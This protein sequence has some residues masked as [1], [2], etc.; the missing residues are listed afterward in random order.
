M[1]G[2]NGL[3]LKHL[4]SVQLSECENC[5][6]EN[7]TIW[8]LTH[9]TSHDCRALFPTIPLLIA[10][11]FVQHAPDC[12]RPYVSQLYGIG[13]LRRRLQGEIY[14]YT[15]THT[16]IIIMLNLNICKFNG[17]VKVIIFN[18]KDTNYIN[19]FCCFCLLFCLLW[20]SVKPLI[21]LITTYF[22]QN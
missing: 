5:L 11:R 16:Y 14:F 20:T 19:C 21:Q 7:N 18:T 9:D 10:I 2:A 17:N 15:F 8:I 13:E 4:S 22:G 1:T 3:D 12:Q 6:E